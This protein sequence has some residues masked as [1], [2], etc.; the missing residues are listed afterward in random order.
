MAKKHGLGRG[1]DAL[2]RDGTASPQPPAEP[3]SPGVQTVA[4]EKIRR[5]EFQPR[6]RFEAEALA[7]LTASIRTHGVLQPLL[8]RPDGNG[9]ELIAGERRLRA[10]GEAGLKT[11]PVIVM[12][13]RDVDA[14][15][16]ALIE[17]LQREDLNIIEEAEGYQSLISQFGFTQ[18]QVAERVGKGRPT[19][20]NALRILTLP[21]EVKQLVANGLLSAGHAKVLTGLD[22]EKEQRLHAKRVIDEGL[23]VRALEKQVQRLKAPAQKP[24][25]SRSDIPP[26]HVSY[27]SDRL[28][29]HFGT[30]VRLS[31]C[32][33]YANGKKGKGC[34][35]IDFYSNDDLTRIL[36]LTGLADE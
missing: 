13:A 36:E 5:N 7:D 29:R 21:D 34:I 35:E 18:E 9:Y 33:T 32:K 6:H 14:L 2:M 15:E 27:L 22:I 20:A 24:R 4:V 25:A 30:S 10:A 28:H 8:V 26:S 17:N 11:V 12:D 31:P 1:L 3:P 19:V 23:S 16:L